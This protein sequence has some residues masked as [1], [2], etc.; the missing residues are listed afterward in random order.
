MEGWI[1]GRGLGRWSDVLCGS[2]RMARWKATVGLRTCLS[3]CVPVRRPVRPSGWLAGGS[4]LPVRIDPV[5]IQPREGS[6]VVNGW[7]RLPWAWA[8]PVASRT[9]PPRSAYCEYF[10]EEERWDGKQVSLSIRRSPEYPRAAARSRRRGKANTQTSRKKQ[11]P[12]SLSRANTR[13]KKPASSS[14]QR[15]PVTI[16]QKRSS[17]A[18]HQLGSDRP[19]I[20]Y[21]LVG[22]RI[23]TNEAN[24]T[25]P[26]Q[27]GLYSPSVSFGND[28][29]QPARRP[30]QPVGRLL[31]AGPDGVQPW[32]AMCCR[33]AVYPDPTSTE[34][35]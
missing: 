21:P 6:Y 28:A 31:V 9:D 13:P 1:G 32:S 25:Q 20:I 3:A 33:V 15:W 34:S 18:A 29:T 10:A 16:S 17:T 7:L 14:V 4:P 30:R 5:P 23:A 2:G 35:I 19:A 12:S 24:V 8:G 11:T 22:S 26:L 27:T